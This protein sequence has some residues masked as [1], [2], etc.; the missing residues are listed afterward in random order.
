MWCIFQDDI[1][2]LSISAH[3]LASGAHGQARRWREE[4][5]VISQ[6]SSGEDR[7]SLRKHILIY[8]IEQQKKNSRSFCDKVGW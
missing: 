7:V 2:M 5:R 4:C 6:V 1:V 3:S 8:A